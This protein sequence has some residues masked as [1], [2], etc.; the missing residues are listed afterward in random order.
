MLKY[1]YI[2]KYILS[3]FNNFVQWSLPVFLLTSVPIVLLK[4]LTKALDKN[5]KCCQSNYF[6]KCCCG[7]ALFFIAGSPEHLSKQPILYG[8]ASLKAVQRRNYK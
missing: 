4:A 6:V 1:I 5:I 2:Y 8:A 7:L 3:A